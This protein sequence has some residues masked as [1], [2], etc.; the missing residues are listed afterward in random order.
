MRCP[1]LC[2]E[3]YPAYLD[4]PCLKVSST[5]DC[6]RNPIRPAC[7]LS[8]GRHP[9]SSRSGCQGVATR[10]MECPEPASYK[11]SRRSASR[12]HSVTPSTNLLSWHCAK[13]VPSSAG[14]HKLPGL[15]RPLRYQ[16]YLPAKRD[17][18]PRLDAPP[19]VFGSMR[20]TRR[21]LHSSRP[22]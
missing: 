17:S 6:V 5:P 14:V 3:T 22:Q 1:C 11:R 20:C 4:I 12:L 21:T 15:E 13:S 7:T 8:R 10:P 18:G 9:L 16:S 2:Q 19:G